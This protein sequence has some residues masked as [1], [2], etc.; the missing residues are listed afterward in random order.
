MLPTLPTVKESQRWTQLRAL[1]TARPG[2]AAIADGL[3]DPECGALPLAEAIPQL[4]AMLTNVG[5]ELPAPEPEPAVETLSE[6]LAATRQLVPLAGGSDL[7]APPYDQ[8]A[9]M[10][11]EHCGADL[12]AQLTD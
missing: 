6:C 5:M 7:A 3:I 11:L 2:F 9:A 10:F 12:L 4:E 1:T 8:V